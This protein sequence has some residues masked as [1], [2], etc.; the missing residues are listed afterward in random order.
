MHQLRSLRVG[1]TLGAHAARG[2]DI[3]DGRL[4]AFTRS[5]AISGARMFPAHSSS[6]CACPCSPWVSHRSSRLWSSTCSATSRRRSARPRRSSGSS[7]SRTR[8]RTGT[9]SPI[10]RSCRTYTPS[11]P[12]SRCGSRSS[13]T[14]CTTTSSLAA[15]CSSALFSF[16]CRRCVSNKHHPRWHEHVCVCVFVRREKEGEAESVSSSHPT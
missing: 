8:T 9:R 2:P 4:I 14:S 10:R 1:T 15:R 7:S 16:S 5:T 12:H 13:R 3:R 11:P 6:C